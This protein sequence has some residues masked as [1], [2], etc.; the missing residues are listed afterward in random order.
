MSKNKTNR[1]AQDAGA[2]NK[3]KNHSLFI[4]QTITMPQNY[5][6]GNGIH[7]GAHEDGGPFNPDSEDIS[8][9]VQ[10]GKNVFYARV[11]KKPMVGMLLSDEG[12]KMFLENMVEAENYEAAANVRDAKNVFFYRNTVRDLI[13][14]FGDEVDI[15]NV[16]LLNGAKVEYFLLGDAT[17]GKVKLMDEE[18]LWDLLKGEALEK[19]RGGDRPYLKSLMEDLKINNALANNIEAYLIFLYGL[20]EELNGNIHLAEG[21]YALAIEHDPSIEQVIEDHRIKGAI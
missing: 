15:E 5:R 19:A 20:A 9:I 13:E 7:T 11:G 17:G 18:E 21:D 3:T 4:A 1:T 14:V 8:L 12:A 6:E 16:S 10:L 2:A